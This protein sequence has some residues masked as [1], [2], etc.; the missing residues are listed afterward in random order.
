MTR[1]DFQGQPAGLVTRTVAATVDALVVAALVVGAWLGVIAVTFVVQKTRFTPPTPSWP[2]LLL[3][4]FWLALVY[5]ALCWG[6]T[7]RTYGDQLLGLRVLSRSGKRLGWLRSIA[8]AAAC[9]VFPIG[10]SW[11]LVDRRNRSVQD[12]VLRSTVVYDWLPRVPT[13]DEVGPQSSSPSTE[14]AG[15]SSIASTRS[16]E[17]TA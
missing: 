16:A 5:L 6:T 3:I 17:E 11:A 14:G 4:G 12:L 10:L 15:R 8:R 7:G 1:P 13:T 2:L 9:V